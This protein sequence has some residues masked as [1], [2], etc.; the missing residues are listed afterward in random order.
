MNAQKKELNEIESITESLSNESGTRPRTI[1][2]VIKPTLITVLAALCLAGGIVLHKIHALEQSNPSLKKAIT[3]TPKINILSQQTA[4]Q[5]THSSIEL[6]SQTSSF[7]NQSPIQKTSID[8][9]LISKEKNQIIPN[10]IDNPAHNDISAE[11]DTTSQEIKM[12]GFSLIDALQFKEHFLTEASCYEDYQKLLNASHKS[13]LATDVLNNLSPYCLSH[14]S[15][16]ENVKNA[17]LKN[18]KR[19]I[20]AYYKENNPE[21]IAYL[22]AIPATLIEIRKINPINDTP[23]DI[24][25]KAQNEIYKQNISQAVDYVTKLP[26]PMQQKMTDFYREA[27]IYNRAKNSI[28][29]LIL[30]FEEK[31]E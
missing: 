10:E 30:S 22:K 31:G 3:S 29:Q 24:L 9:T 1:S 28:D 18:K 6:S 7:M 13:H 11:N 23:K 26:L 21:W 4:F 27:A 17:F 20:V 25:H 16:V 14:Q 15:A 5:P 8:T 2:R 19:A 12:E